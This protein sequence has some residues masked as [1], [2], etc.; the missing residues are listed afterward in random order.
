MNFQMRREREKVTRLGKRDFIQMSSCISHAPHNHMDHN[1]KDTM[2]FRVPQVLKPLN[3]KPF[4]H[5]N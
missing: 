4:P 5:M 2:G 3:S 1:G